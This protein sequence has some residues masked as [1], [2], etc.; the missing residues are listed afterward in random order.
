MKNYKWYVFSII[1]LLSIVAYGV[2]Y[3]F[4]DF[5]EIDG[6]FKIWGI[7]LYLIQLGNMVWTSLNA[8]YFIKKMCQS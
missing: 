8:F 5:K 4:F 3:F 6:I 2:S 1:Q 7:I